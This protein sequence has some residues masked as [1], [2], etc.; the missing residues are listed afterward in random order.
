[1]EIVMSLC[2]VCPSSDT[3][4]VAEVLLTCFESRDKVV[5]LLRAV[6]QKEISLTGKF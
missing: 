6:V 5:P 3:T 1:M 4:G 2:E